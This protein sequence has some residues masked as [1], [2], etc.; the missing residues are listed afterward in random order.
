MV[1]SYLKVMYQSFF[2][3]DIMKTTRSKIERALRTTQRRCK[4]AYRVKRRIR[5]CLKIWM[6]K[7]VKK[8]AGTPLPY[9]PEIKR[10]LR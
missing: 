10:V 4:T 5:H 8:I 2:T 9:C 1:Y 7:T 3:N 6:I